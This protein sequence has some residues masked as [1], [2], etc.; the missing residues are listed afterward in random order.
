[1][2]TK[3]SIT[4]D[5]CSIGWTTTAPN[6]AASIALPQG[7]SFL[8]A[9]QQLLMNTYARPDIVF[10]RGSGVFLYDTTGKQ[11]LDFMA[12]IAVTSFGHCDPLWASTLNKQALKLV[13]TSNLY[14]SEPAT[15]LAYGLVCNSLFDK[16]FICN[17][18]TEANEAALKFARKYARDEL[19]K[20]H[21]VNYVAFTNGFSG[22]SMGSLSCT[23]KSKYR[24]PFMIWILLQKF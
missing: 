8:K 4:G 3:C 12:G 14:H 21:K 16:A 6:K 1:L 13:H 17:S 7:E 24:E 19:K 20:D 15:Q 5:H 11:Y 18:G 2:L 10:T 23:H 22:R 9:T